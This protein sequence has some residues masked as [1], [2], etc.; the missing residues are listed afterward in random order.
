MLAHFIAIDGGRLGR[1]LLTQQRNVL[2]GLQFGWI[3]KESGSKSVRLGNELAM[4][5]LRRCA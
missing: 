3:P 1:W 4:D 2:D 5:G